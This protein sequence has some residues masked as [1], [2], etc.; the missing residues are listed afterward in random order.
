MNEFNKGSVQ[1]VSTKVFFLFLSVFLGVSIAFAKVE[2]V[3]GNVPL[4]KNDNLFAQVSMPA[5][6]EIIISRNQ[7]VISYNKN[8]RAPNWVAWK[9]DARELGNAGRVDRFEPDPDLANYLSQNGGL[10]AVSPEDYKN[11]CFDR[12][13]QVPSADRTDSPQ[14][15]ASTF[16]M[17][18]MIPQTPYLNRVIWVQLEQYTRDLVIKSG[19]NVYMIAG[20]V[21]DQDFGAIG[22]QQDIPVPSKDFKIIVVL[23]ANQT[24]K[25]ITASTPVLAVVM[26]NTL[27]DGTKPLADKTKLCNPQLGKPVNDWQSYKTTVGELQKLSGLRVMPLAK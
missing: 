3:L 19:K 24:P 10:K 8:R 12:G 22:P 23:E 11:T 7:Y 21:Y 15:N 14:D 20:P 1:K 4:E 9:L 6:S 27:E 16:Y 13:H 25:D 18:N 2:A 26:P 5:N 17:S